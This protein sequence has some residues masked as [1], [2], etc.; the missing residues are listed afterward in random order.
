[1]LGAADPFAWQPD[2]LGWTLVPLLAVGYVSAL[3][4][5]SRGPL[6]LPKVQGRQRAAFAAGLFALWLALDW[7]LAELGRRWSLM[8]HM[9]QISLLAMV[10]AP[11]L[12]LGTPRW[13]G[14]RLTRPPSVDAVVRRVSHPAVATVVFNGAILASLLPPVVS[15]QAANGAVDGLVHV[16]LLAAGLVMWMP[17]LRFPGTRPLSTAARIGY[18]CVQAI[19][20]SFPALVFIFAAHPLYPTFAHAR[21]ALGISAVADQQLAGALAKVFGL[22]VLGLAIGVI[23]VRA[24]RAESAGL[25]PDPLTWDDVERELRRLDRHHRKTDAG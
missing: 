4:S 10:A 2:P 6:V 5:A 14:E 7:P 11:L 25:D 3:R 17:A 12:L 24:E 8:A 13:L 22:G 23:L 19:L 18:L 20:P 9:A 15:A 21:E 1:V 16:A